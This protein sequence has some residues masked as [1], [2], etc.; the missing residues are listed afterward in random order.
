MRGETI[1]RNYAET[2]LELA[3][4]ANDA[5]GWG[6][7][8]DD[9]AAAMQQDRNVWLF[10]ESP[11]VSGS[12]KNAVLRKALG[13]ALPSKFVRFIEAL[14]NHRRQMLIPEI[15]REYH[16]LLDAA[17]GRVHAN[18]VVAQAV[19]DKE[20]NAIAE[21]LSKVLGKRVVPHVAVNPAIIGGLVVR[22]GDVV[23]DGSVRKRLASL[24]SRML[25]SR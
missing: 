5:E 4:R 9:L 20:R 8:I 18:V 13:G 16:D 25:T 22:V 17:E 12:E 23:L 7:T 15:A 21:R 11:R 14:V 1:A 19:D 3:R 10:L 24:K 2:M 6:R